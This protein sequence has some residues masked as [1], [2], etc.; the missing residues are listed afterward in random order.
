MSIGSI[1]GSAASAFDGAS[2]AQSA[3]VTQLETSL[4]GGA[5]DQPA[6]SVTISALALAIHQQD[7]SQLLASSIV[8]PIR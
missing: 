6:T 4:L 2:A 5:T 7:V 3:N 1:Q 8:P